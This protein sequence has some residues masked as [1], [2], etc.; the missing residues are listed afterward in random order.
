MPSSSGTAAT[1]AARWQRRGERGPSR[2]SDLWLRSRGRV[3]DYSNFSK[4]LFYF[5]PN[6][7]LRA[8]PAPG[9][10][11]Y[12][13]ATMDALGTKSTAPWVVDAPRRYSTAPWAALE[14][15]VDAQRSR[16]PRAQTHRAMPLDS[17]ER[18]EVVLMEA[19]VEVCVNVC[20]NMCAERGTCG[21]VA[22]QKASP[23]CAQVEAE[24][25]RE[26]GRGI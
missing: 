10:A 19:R 25:G 3:P 17:W 26:K 6:P 7:G 9:D 24:S 8:V 2:A 13:T 18:I 22:S 14:A 21:G 23:R 11:L 16:P 20:V 12:D 4:L 5:C 1:V 15:Y